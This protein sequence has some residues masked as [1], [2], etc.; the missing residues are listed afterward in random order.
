MS[1]PLVDLFIILLIL[2]SGAL[3]LV[4]FAH[5]ASQQSDV[6]IFP[7][8]VD[9]TLWLTLTRREKDVA[10]LVVRG[11]TNDEIGRELAIKPRTVDAH[12]QRI[13]FKL[14]VHSRV[15]LAHRYHDFAESTHFPRL[16]PT[17]RE[18]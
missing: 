8:P 15:Q 11:F 7:N 16:S 17:V 18:N 6:P 14:E 1:L 5:R 3:A 10:R 2:E 13:Y 4:I 12:I 9:L